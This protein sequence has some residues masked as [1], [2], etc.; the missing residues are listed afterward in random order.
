M[1]R[2]ALLS[3]SLVMMAALPSV[4][5]VET[6]CGWLDNPTPGNWWLTDA[7]G[8]WTMMAQGGYQA[9]GM[10]KIP[11][12]KPNQYVKTNGSY[13]YTCACMNVTTSSKLS[14]IRRIYSVKPLKLSQ[15]RQDPKLPDR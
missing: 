6:R 8:R 10:D 4:A 13:G 9:Q 2:K 5:A 7:D 1:F 12:F 14:R 11:E 15:C 3:V